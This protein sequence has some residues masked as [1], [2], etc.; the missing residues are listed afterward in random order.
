MSDIKSGIAYSPMQAYDKSLLEVSNFC[1]DKA[2]WN[3]AWLAE[4]RIDDEGVA[5][6]LGNPIA[7][8][9]DEFMDK[10]TREH[11]RKPPLDFMRY[12][13]TLLKQGDPALA[14]GWPQHFSA[15]M[16]I[17]AQDA[18]ERLFGLVLEGNVIFAK[19]GRLH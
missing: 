19:F 3:L 13:N 17:R 4:P 1:F 2:K 15:V 12:W 5:A 10:E 11:L 8:S 16:E 9:I 18:Q 7:A 6:L 14:K